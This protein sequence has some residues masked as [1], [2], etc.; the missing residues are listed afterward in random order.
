MLYWKAHFFTMFSLWQEHAALSP[1]V[2]VWRELTLNCPVTRGTCMEYQRT[3]VMATVGP[4]SAPGV[5]WASPCWLDSFVHLHHL[6]VAPAQWR[7]RP[8]RKMAVCDHQCRPAGSSTWVW[9]PPS[10]FPSSK[11]QVSSNESWQSKV[12]HMCTA[13]EPFWLQTNST[14]LERNWTRLSGSNCVLDS[15]TMVLSIPHM[16]FASWD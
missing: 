5:G 15:L 2:P 7:R 11:I 1:C 10:V 6:S 4:C 16:L 12:G 13:P 8:D 9:L 14:L 3:S